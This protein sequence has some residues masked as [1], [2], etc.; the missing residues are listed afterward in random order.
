[1]EGSFVR[2]CFLKSLPGGLGGR[3][4]LH[5]VTERN[6]FFLKTKAMFGSFPETG[7]N[8]C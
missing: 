5:T 2:L 7:K 4:K 6:C 1:M 8:C 3:R